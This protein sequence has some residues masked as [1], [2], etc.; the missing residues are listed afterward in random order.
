MQGRHCHLDQVEWQ[1]LKV[2]EDAKDPRP[3]HIIAGAV[4]AKATRRVRGGFKQ[5]LLPASVLPWQDSSQQ[6]G[7]S[8][9]A[10]SGKAKGVARIFCKVDATAQFGPMPGIE[11]VSTIE[12]VPHNV[13]HTFPGGAMP[14]E[15]FRP[16]GLPRRSIGRSQGRACGHCNARQEAHTRATCSKLVQSQLQG[17]VHGETIPS[18]G[19]KVFLD[20]KSLRQ[21]LRQNQRPGIQAWR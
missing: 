7:T 12:A 1:G 21:Q 5:S 15:P 17:A 10:L 19:I 4:E 8:P 16:Q 2:L 3:F 14:Q 9:L 18:V 6:H 13:W 11:S 20:Q